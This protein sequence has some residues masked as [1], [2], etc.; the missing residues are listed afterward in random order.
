MSAFAQFALYLAIILLAAKLAGGLSLRLGQPSILGELIAGLLLGPTLL[1][2]GRWSWLSD[3]AAATGIDLL[4]QF[5]VVVLMFAAGLELHVGELARNAQPSGL[6]AGF[7][8]L[9]S[10][11]AGWAVGMLFGMASKSALMLGLMIGATSV[12]ISVQTL[13]ELK[14]LKSRVGL[15]ILGAAVCD[16]ILVLLLLAF[17]SAIQGGGRDI[18][19]L[20]L[21]VGRALAFFA[22]TIL[23][24]WFILPRLM[25]WT[26]KLPVSQGPLALAVCTLLIYGTAAEAVGGMA[27]IMGAFIA[28][29][30]FSRL[31]EKTQIDAGVHAIGYGLLIPIFFVHL[32]M[33]LDLRTVPV[34]G[35]GLLAGLTAAAVGAKIVGAGLGSRLGGFSLKEAV[36]LGAGMVP[37]GEVSL[38]VGAVGLQQGLVTA[39]DISVVVGLVI[40]TTLITPPLLRWLMTSSRF[41]GGPAEIE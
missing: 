31:R 3:P 16:D 7:G 35:I 12:S 21:V 2:L 19:S 26:R 41:A 24:G 17:T 15:G 9:F 6:A 34:S 39:A 36:R 37:R 32:G 25:A 14:A 28:G 18:G 23:F 29:L 13:I 38:I 22:G 27:P 10:V 5:G 30:M 33:S 8:V 20:A 11:G 40:L 4:A 1:D